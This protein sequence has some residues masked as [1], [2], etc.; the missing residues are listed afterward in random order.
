MN[1]GLAQLGNPANFLNPRDGYKILDYSNQKWYK[2]LKGYNEKQPASRVETVT[3]LDHAG[4]VIYVVYTNGVKDEKLTQKLTEAMKESWLDRSID[5]IDRFLDVVGNVAKTT[6][7]VMTTIT[8][9][10]GTIGGCAVVTLSTG[11]IGI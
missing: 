9:I 1:T 11:G 3:E 8:G 6:L 7:G 4:N 2:N 5:A 10:V